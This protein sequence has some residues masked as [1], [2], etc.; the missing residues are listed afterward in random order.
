M[1]G[2]H[3][4]AVAFGWVLRSLRRARGLSQEDLAA[5]ADLDRTYPSLLERGLRT[6]TLTVV[7]DFGRA[8][9][10]E[11]AQLVSATIER[12][13]ETHY[14]DPTGLHPAARPHGAA[15]S[16]A[17]RRGASTCAGGPRRW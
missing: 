2:R 3:N 7:I 17:G 12:L 9:R 4:V 13:R 10:V 11:P 14:E 16:N 5:I 15:L 8:L 6:P 1:S